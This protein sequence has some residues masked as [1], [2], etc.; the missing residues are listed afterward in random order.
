MVILIMG[1]KQKVRAKLNIQTG[2]IEPNITIALKTYKAFKP[3]VL[4]HIQYENLVASFL[5]HILNQN[6]GVSQIIRY[7]GTVYCLLLKLI[8]ISTTHD[9]HSE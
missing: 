6:F 9:I 8:G 4:W 5:L 7:K 2:W 3:L 1:D